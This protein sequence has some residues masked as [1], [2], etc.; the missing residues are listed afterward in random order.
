VRRRPAPV[1]AVLEAAQYAGHPSPVLHARFDQAIE[2]QNRTPA[3]QLI[4]T[5]GTGRGDTTAE[6]TEGRRYGIPRGAIAREG[7]RKNHRAINARI[8]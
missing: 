2:L 1:I 3:S 6:A 4:L 8:G 5:E 7:N